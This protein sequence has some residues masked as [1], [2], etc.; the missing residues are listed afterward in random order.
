MVKTCHRKLQTLD[1]QECWEETCHRKLQTLDRTMIS[2]NL[3]LFRPLR[4]KINLEAVNSTFQEVHQT[5]PK[6]RYGGFLSHGGTPFHNPFLFGIVHET[7]LPIGVAP[8]LPYLS[9]SS[10]IKGRHLDV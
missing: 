10:A 6:S 8:Y 5:S 7:I 4:F 3:G 9:E 1:A 2:D